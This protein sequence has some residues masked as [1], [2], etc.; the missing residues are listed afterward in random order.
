MLLKAVQ[1]FYVHTRACVR[2]GM[3]VSEWF[4]VNVGLGQGRVMCAW[5]F[6]TQIRML[7]CERSGRAGTA[8]CEWWQ[9]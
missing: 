8:E 5:L 2:V 9:V 4:P 6:K 1:N 3:N 7:W